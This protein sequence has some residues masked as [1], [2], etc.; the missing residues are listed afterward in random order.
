MDFTRARSRPDRL[1]RRL[2][3]NARFGASDSSLFRASC[4]LPF[5]LQDTWASERGAARGCYTGPFAACMRE[6]L[7]RD[8]GFGFPDSSRFRAYDHSDVA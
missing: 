6:C 5:R 8:A 7:R 1:W 2:R 4:S 3:R